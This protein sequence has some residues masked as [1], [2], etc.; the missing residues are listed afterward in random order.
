[1]GRERGRYG[2][3]QRGE[4]TVI[5]AIVGDSGS[6][7]TTLSAALAAT[8]GHDRVTTICLDDYHRYDRAERARLDITALS[9]ECNRLDLMAEHL[10]ALR[11]GRSILKP[12]YHHTHGT[13]GPDEQLAPRS[14]VIARGLLAL[15]TPELRSAFD[16]TVFLDPDPEL[17][18]QWK[19]ARDT[20]KRGY[21]P[22][23]VRQHLRRR[24]PDVER[25]IAPQR[26]HA[27]VV[28]VYSP[29]LAGPLDLR[30]EIRSRDARGLDM[31]L[32]AAERARD[33]ALTVASLPVEAR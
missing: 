22:E 29:T 28:I 2:E 10:H 13:F 23:E 5:I 1:L 9:P 6:G 14:I 26:A 27:S 12:V 7:K 19:I 11:A 15:H 18:V 31:V 21:T 25:Y 8:I 17:R 33:Q 20:A 30:T 24:Q 16:L 4:E 3:T 32:A